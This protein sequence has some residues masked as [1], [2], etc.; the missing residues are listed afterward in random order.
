MSSA[1]VTGPAP[2]ELI[3]QLTTGYVVTAALYATTKLGIPDLL[4][5]GPRSVKEL[6]TASGANEDALYRAL[7]ALASA[8]V[9]QETTPRVFASTP[10]AETLRANAPNSMR[11]ALLW[12]ADPFHFRV[13]AEMPHALQNGQT[14]VERVVG[15]PIFEYFTE[16]PAESEVFNRAMTYFSAALIPAVLEVYDFSYLNGKTLV[17]VAGGHGYVLTAILQKYPQI[18]GVLFDLEHVVAGAH[19]HIS[20]LNLKDRCATAHGDFFKAV[21][22]GDAYI[23]KNIIH[24]WNDEQAAT[25][26]KCCHRASPQHAKVILVETVIPPGND[27]HMG[28]WLDLEMLL[29]AGGRERSDDQ[30]RALFTQAGFRLTKIQCTNSPMCVIEAEKL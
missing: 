23:M 19:P 29:M 7:R 10:A 21:P 18:H 14:V 6:A 26:L 3:M 12:I 27:P 8:G 20:K 5:D 25:I 4:Q 2:N 24:D 11:D 15:K 9:F 13:F 22:P 30:F 1:P 16:D 17:D 28:K